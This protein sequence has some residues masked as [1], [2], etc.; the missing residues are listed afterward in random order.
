VGFGGA[1]GPWLGGYIYDVMGSYKVAFVISMVAVGLAGISLW[2][3]APRNA[4]KLRAKMLG[5]G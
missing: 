4:E 1:I 3:A 5:P 2:I